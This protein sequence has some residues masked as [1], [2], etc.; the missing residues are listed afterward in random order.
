LLG[1]GGAVSINPSV[2][3]ALSYVPIRGR[4]GV[5]QVAE[6][7]NIVVVNPAMPPNTIAELIAYVRARQGELNYGAAGSASQ[8]RLEMEVFMAQQGLR[9]VHI[10]YRGGAGPTVTDLLAGRVGLM[11][12]TLPAVLGHVR[13]GRIKA[14]ALTTQD[15]FP[16]LP[17]VATMLEQ[18]FD[19]NVSS[20]WQGL[21]VPAAT[22]AA[23]VQRIF[24]AAVAAMTEEAVN[25][26]LIEAGAISSVSASPAAFNTLVGSETRRWR[27]AVVAVGARPD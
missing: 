21:L 23:I 18:G 26:R 11:V 13:A 5:T 17:E 3:T 4:A 15:R 9:I 27:E 12:M 7:P 20:S 16:G 2:F 10:P 8:N 25:R 6:T 14:L 24:D 1:N 22:P 19:A